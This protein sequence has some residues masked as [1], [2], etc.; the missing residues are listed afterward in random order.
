MKDIFGNLI[1]PD[2]DYARGKILKSSYEEKLKYSQS[3]KLIA[4]RIEKYGEESLSVFTGNIRSNQ[5]DPSDLGILSEE[6]IGPSLF[7]EQLKDVAINHV[8][9]N[10]ETDDVA[11]LNRT[12]AANICALLALGTSGKT[13][14]SFAPEKKHHPSV[15]R[16]A[17]LAQL[18]LQSISDVDEMKRITP[19]PEGGVCLITSVTSEL[20][21]LNDEEMKCVIR[22]A[23]TMG[24]DVVVD[25][26][27]GARIR[28]ILLNF[29]PALKAGADVVITNNDKAGLNGPRAGI[30]VG[31][32]DL[33]AK[34][35]AKANELGC[36][37]RAP[38]SLAVYRS[39]SKFSS[40]DLLEEVQIGKEI[41]SELEKEI[42]SENVR[43]SLLG[44]EVTADTILNLLL[45]KEAS[46]A[47]ETVLVPAEATAAL[48]MEMLKRHGIITTNACGMPGARISVRLKT[49]KQNLDKVG[50]AR[51]VV[52]AF[53]D[54]LES[55]RK[56]AKDLGAASKVI[57]GA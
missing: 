34:I 49:N 7:Y 9:G 43:S 3:I 31:R 2:V 22:T 57:L 11:I 54:S 25:D 26:A 40:Q 1:D 15:N 32:K 41:F 55:V 33:V 42:G 4:E 38:I 19:S 45:E 21:Y 36:E 23:K 29:S 13:A 20:L 37:A 27:Y 12:S 16:G 18:N 30:M 28:P 8:S 56:Y 17:R 14:V 10:R 6:W 53:L 52:E 35:S 50:S 44:P 39:L 48:G 5:L 51:K 46:K 47:H 24:L